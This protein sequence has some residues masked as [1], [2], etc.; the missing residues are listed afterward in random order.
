MNKLK[1]FRLGPFTQK[2]KMHL[3]AF[4]LPVLGMLVVF[5]GNE[6]WPVG[7]RCFLRTDLYHQYAPFHAELLRKLQNG[8]SLFYTWT[9]GM[10]TNFWALIGY[11]LASVSN[12]FLLVVPEGLIID[13]I[14]YMVV[15]KMGLAGL[16]FSCL[17][18]RRSP[19]RLALIPM[20]S[21]FYAM[22]GYLAAYSWNVMWMDC[23]W[24]APLILLGIEKLVFDRKPFL[25][26]ISLAMG[27]LSNYYIGIMLCIFC[28]FYYLI[29]MPDM[30]AKFDGA[31]EK[32]AEF[33][34]RGILFALSSLLAGGLTSIILI[35]EFK[36][37]GLTASS[38]ISFPT[39]WEQYFEILDMIGRHLMNVDIENG[40]DHWPN[41]YCGVAVLICLPLY[42]LNKK[43]SLPSKLCKTLLAVFMLFSFSTNVMAFLWHGFHYPNSLPS[44]QSFLYI[45]LILIMCYEGL[46]GLRRVSR[47]T[48]GIICAASLLGIIL[49]NRLVED[50]AY[51]MYT[52]WASIAFVLLYCSLM[53]LFRAKKYLSRS[54]IVILA[55]VCVFAES[56][57]NMAVTSV[58]TVSRSEYL[59]YTE[60]YQELIAKVQETDPD[61]YRFEKVARKTKNDGAFVGYP[62]I[63]TFSS[64][65]YGNM[66]DFYGDL[67]MEQSMNAY[68]NNGITPLMNS[69]LGVKYILTTTPYDQ[70]QL[71]TLYEQNESCY[72]YENHYTMSVGF[73]LPENMDNDWDTDYGSIENQ[74]DFAFYAGEE[75]LFY[76]LY[77]CEENGD[78]FTVHTEM[79]CHVFVEL[80]TS[81]IPSIDASINGTTKTFSNTKRCYLL[82][83]GYISPEDEVILTAE[84]GTLS[85]TAYYLEEDN[86]INLVKKLKEQQ[87]SVSSWDATHVEGTIEVQEDGLF[88][89]SIPYDPGWTLKVDGVETEMTAFKESFLSCKLSQGSHTISLSYTPQGFKSGAM[90]TLISMVIL[91]LWI[92]IG[93]RLSK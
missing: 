86:L 76:Q 59:N 8:E 26:I 84:E 23:V 13:F 33:F 75:Q 17:L 61:L 42:Y 51:Y 46:L 57:I 18:Y 55:L 90:L 80:D 30:L 88:F 50:D 20:V 82:D 91:A 81:S 45:A 32:W 74:N 49:L 10:G 77:N 71:T 25:Y 35:P 65:S 39:K 68:C 19:K 58:T 24:M 28:V 34:K 60:P 69:L 67:G 47:Q 62:S 36:M 43:I 15:F 29:Q 2:R 11:Y 4:L 72:V 21:T 7:D 83:L 53:L 9:V 79:N 56:T 12:L 64:V 37:L 66:S 40:L 44:R 38:D 41:I 31:K 78:T 52:Y 63:S 89:L 22:S 1:K 70:S 54:V 6:I 16:T 73:M 85:A 27:I 3:V 93:K 14:S 92:K 48:I 5:A 87:M